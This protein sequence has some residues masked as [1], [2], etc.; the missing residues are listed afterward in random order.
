MLGE[1]KFRVLP[2]K[3]ARLRS[4]RF[5]DLKM[6]P[7]GRMAWRCYRKKPPAGLIKV[8]AWPKSLTGA[9]AQAVNAY[10]LMGAPTVT[11]P[12]FAAAQVRPCASQATIL[13]G[14]E[15]NAA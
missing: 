7:T 15:A 4:I 6:M 2:D 14:E 12:G 3:F 5:I 13:C 10:S 9:S 11:S 8:E 1:A